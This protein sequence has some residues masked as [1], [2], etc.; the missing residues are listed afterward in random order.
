M[1]VCSTWRAVSRVDYLWERLVRRIWRRTHHL[2]ATWREEFIFWHRTASNFARARYL[3]YSLAHHDD[4]YDVDDNDPDLLSCRC[5]TL[6]DY[7]LA[8]GFADGT[9]RLFDLETRNHVRTFGALHTI[10][11]GRFSRAVSGI[12]LTNN[13]IIFATLIGDIYV[14]ILNG[15]PHVRIAGDFM[16]NGVLVEFSGSNRFWVGLYAGAQGRTFQV[17]DAHTEEP[18]F[19]GGDLT[20]PDAVT[21]WHMLTHVMEPLGRIRVTSREFVIACTRSRLVI[22]DLRNPE[23]L[24]HDEESNIGLIVTTLDV[25]R[26]PEVLLHEGGEEFNV[27]LIEDVSHEAFIIVDRNGR[28]RVRRV[29]TLDQLYAFR[30]RAA[31]LEGLMGCMNLCYALMCAGGVIRVWDVEGYNG[32][33][34]AAR[35][36][37]RVGEANAMVANDRHVAL[38][39]ADRSIRLWD[40]GV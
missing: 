34:P 15:P 27:G 38:A 24:L 9:V 10:R 20:E 13:R 21:G 33:R 14:A 2:R 25:N 22:F 5:L 11:V 3:Y 19:V 36:S 23:V 35:I 1:Q 30:I 7:H 6:S 37:E 40:F 4:P 18:I 31:W 17:W 8:C 12:V 32:Q 16:N 29:S 26:K 39:C 28:A